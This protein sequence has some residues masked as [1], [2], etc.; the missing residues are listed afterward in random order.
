MLTTNLTPTL[1]VN[2][3]KAKETPNIMGI[4]KKVLIFLPELMYTYVRTL[5]LSKKITAFAFEFIHSFIQ[6]FLWIFVCFYFFFPTNWKQSF[7]VEIFL[8]KVKT[9]I[10]IVT[11]CLSEWKVNQKKQKR[12]K[13]HSSIM[14]AIHGRRMRKCDCRCFLLTSLFKVPLI[15]INSLMFSSSCFYVFFSQIFIGSLWFFNVL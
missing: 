12:E 11:I 5:F 10:I 4:I 15:M 7:A 8:T 9:C 6:I 1:K 3:K 14:T 13:K 2:V